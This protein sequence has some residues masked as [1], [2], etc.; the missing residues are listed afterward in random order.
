[1]I[2]TSGLGSKTH[3][4]TG[5]HKGKYVSVFVDNEGTY[6]QGEKDCW[7]SSA[8]LYKNLDGGIWIPNSNSKQ[9]PRFWFYLKRSEALTSKG[10]IVAALDK[11][12]AGNVKKES[13]TKIEPFL[14]N[15]ITINYE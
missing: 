10:G 2:S 4:S 1:M 13:S 5:L 8:G 7:Y 12:D 9:E 15:Q 14:L 3:Y 11:M 6:Y